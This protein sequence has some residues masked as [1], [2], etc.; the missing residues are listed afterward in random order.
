[1]YWCKIL[2]ACTRVAEYKWKE[3]NK[4]KRDNRGR[5]KTELTGHYGENGEESKI[6]C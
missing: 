3:K 4:K 2:E 1:M 6:T 5:K